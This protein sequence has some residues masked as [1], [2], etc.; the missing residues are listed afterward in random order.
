MEHLVASYEVLPLRAQYSPPI[1]P[2]QL[3][4]AL[5]S[6]SELKRVE[7]L[8]EEHGKISPDNLHAAVK[9]ISACKPAERAKLAARFF[10]D[11]TLYHRDLRRM[12]ADVSALDGV[13]IITSERFRERS[14]INNT[15]YEFLLPEEQRPAEEDKV[16]HHVILKADIRES[17]TLTRTL[18]ERGLNPASYFSLSFYDPINKLLP[19][20]EARKVFIEGDAIILALFEREGE[21]ALGV[22]QTCVLAKE[23][24]E[25]VTAYN[26]RSL[27]SGLPS[28]ELGIGISY[29]DSA[30]MYLMDGTRQIMISKAI[31]ETDRL[32]PS[33]TRIPQLLEPPELLFTL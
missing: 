25:I 30:P 21:P 9:K 12:E 23:I 20:Y 17:T 18:F 13:N 24:I 3:K 33:S 19:K 16:I 26:D 5:I 8:L 1:T 32:P 6:R 4:N 11:F 31:N 22:A 10:T 2:R 29:Q 7:T 27:A 14:A 15:L 28:L